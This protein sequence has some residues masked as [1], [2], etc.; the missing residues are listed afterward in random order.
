MT[1]YFILFLSLTS[2]IL[3][4]QT[5][6]LKGQVSEA[7]SP[8]SFVTI[9]LTQEPETINQ[10]TSSTFTGQIVAA[11]ISGDDGSF[12]IEDLPEGRY[13]LSAQILGFTSYQRVVTLGP[14]LDLGQIELTPSQEQLEEVT[15]TTKPPQITLEPGR[16]V[17]RVAESSLST[18]DS[19]NVITKT[20]GMVVLNGQLT[21]KNRPT[22]IYLNNKKL[23][24]EGSELKDFLEGLDAKLK[25][26]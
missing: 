18:T 19:Y 3:L 2:T 11:T 7:N 10:A 8:L 6:H 25:K 17:F 23:Y 15:I 12:S 14:S 26:K 24:L 16:L 5:Y 20:P 13:G 1:K 22:I 4:G 21:I 9:V